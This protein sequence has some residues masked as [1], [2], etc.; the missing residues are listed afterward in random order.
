M[1]VSL[2]NSRLITVLLVIN[3]Q[4]VCYYNRAVGSQ[5]N[6]CASGTGSYP[7]WCVDMV[8]HEVNTINGHN[9]LVQ[10][11]RH[12]YTMCTHRGATLPDVYTWYIMKS[13]QS[14]ATTYW[15]SGC[16][17]VW[18]LVSNVNFSESNTLAFTCWLWQWTTGR[19][20]QNTSTLRSHRLVSLSTQCC[21]LHS[22]L[23]HMAGRTLLTIMK[24]TISHLIKHLNCQMII[25]YVATV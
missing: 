11:M 17:A 21:T 14:M 18:R 9:V 23:C 5:Q 20:Q 3:Y 16:D 13:T 1:P 24:T 25:T 10:W 8:Y 7:P 15:C 6:V 4:Q 19:L 12:W 22:Q 2:T